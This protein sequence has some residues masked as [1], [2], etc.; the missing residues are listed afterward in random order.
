MPSLEPDAPV[1]SAP[2]V[3]PAV[4][5]PRPLKA[6]VVGVQR[7]PAPLKKPVNTLAIV[8]KSARITSLGRK[9]YN[10]LLYEAQD[11]GL[12]KDV[13]RVPLDRVV[14]GVDF[15]SNDHALIKKHLRA[16]VSTTVEW[17]SPT[18]GEGAAWNV[19]G[20]LAHAR[21]TKER[22]QVWVEWSYAVNLKQELLEPTVFAR[23]KL[24]II[25]Q[26]RSHAGIALYEI[27]TRYKDIGRTSRQPW[28]WWHPVLS[29]QPASDRTAKLEYRIFK[30]D[31]LKP[32]M[33]EVSAVTDLEVEL[34]EHKEGRF[35]SEIQFLIRPKSQTPLAL[36]QPPEP[37]DLSLVARARDL[38]VDEDKAEDLLQEFGGQA[39]AA[40]LEILA[41]R[42]ASS[43]P[44]PLKDPYR[45]LRALMPGQVPPK[46]EP[47]GAGQA[48]LPATGSG[49]AEARGPDSSR[50]AQAKRQTRWTEEWIRRRREQVVEQIAAMSPEGQGTL[51]ADL[52]A[53]MERRQVHPSIRKRLQTSGWQHPMVLPEMV[54]Y[55]A[56][57]SLGEQWDKPTPQQLLQIAAELGDAS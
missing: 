40:A 4:S 42:A 47:E 3:G 56:V 25:S 15:D 34:Q 10:V 28:R 19:S 30:R 55:Y 20:L 38:G 13:F 12:D 8:P 22:G 48:V 57:G 43:F 18:T 54:R 23:L 33:A 2:D 9:A 32:A 5:P 51:S 29:G 46:P 41:Q 16:M 11:Q 50:D 35:I 31:T 17:Q 14:R 27:C 24:E 26:L 53:D 49:T 36:K 44:Q 1:F 37:I 7:S 6:P 52:L 45:Y 21:L 39:M